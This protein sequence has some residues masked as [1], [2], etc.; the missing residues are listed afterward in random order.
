MTTGKDKSAFIHVLVADDSAFMR[1]AITRMIESDPGLRVT[2]TAQTG[3]EALDKVK[4]LKPD[5]VTL[6]VEMPGMNGL[7]TL[8]HIMKECP[9]QVIMVSCLTQ[10]GAEVTLEALDIG[11]FDY[12]PKQSSF[13][14]LDIVKIREEL[15]SKIKAAAESKRPLRRAAPPAASRPALATPKMAAIIAALGTST[16][17]PKALQEMLPLLPGD[18]NVPI[19]I[20]QHMPQ[21][22]T[23]PFA[24]RL[25]GL[26]NIRV[27]EAIQEEEIQPGVAYIAPAGQHMTVYRRG[28]S[29]AALRL[30]QTP[31]GLLHMPSVDVMMS[32]VAE[33]FHSLTLGVILTGM[34]ADGCKGM[35]AIKREG[36]FNLGQDEASCTV[37]GMPRSAAEA[38]VLHRVVPLLHVP[39]QI[40]QLTHYKKSAAHASG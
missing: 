40:M 33:V 15:V 29:K 21:G 5:V 12:V 28:S 23:G 30:A 3:H 35:Q 4:A 22:F 18:L 34:G 9:T 8:R 13:V 24:R 19:L 1:T 6:D 36:G 17:G 26:C 7:E 2:A 25:D 37:Y 38:G 31:T 32:S 14:S 27:H 39:D 11:A 20:V 10:E 16:G